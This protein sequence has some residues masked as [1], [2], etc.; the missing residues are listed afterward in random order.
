[1][2][3]LH[4][5][6]ISFHF[7]RPGCCRSSLNAFFL[8]TLPVQITILR[9]IVAHTGV[10]TPSLAGFHDRSAFRAIP[11]SGHSPLPR[12]TRRPT[13]MYCWKQLCC[14]LWVYTEVTPKSLILLNT[15]SLRY[16]SSLQGISCL[17]P[18]MFTL[19]NFLSASFKR[20][21]HDRSQSTFRDLVLV[22][23]TE[24]ALS[25]FEESV[26]HSFEATIDCEVNRCHHSGNKAVGFRPTLQAMN[27]FT[28][29]GP[30]RS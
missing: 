4:N 1:M 7:L 20:Y 27:A 8:E 24:R 9:V 15:F 30:T 17:V 5:Y 23:S 12:A 16:L 26:A 21:F 6:S 11:P 14:I 22:L 25:P 19:Y 10:L 18:G 28:E 13:V 3:S 2:A 29:S